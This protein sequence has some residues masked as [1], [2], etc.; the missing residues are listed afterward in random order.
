MARSVV[1]TNLLNGEYVGTQKGYYVKITSKHIQFKVDQ[2]L[3]CEFEVPV[4]IQV[5]E[6]MATVTVIENES[7]APTSR[8]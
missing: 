3:K 8:T 4:R 2:G 5:S 1:L 6:G 7:N